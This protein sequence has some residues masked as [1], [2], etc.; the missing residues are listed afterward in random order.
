MTTKNT[1][2]IHC[3]WFQYYL[4]VD[5]IS[6][7]SL[8]LTHLNQ[9][10]TFWPITNYS[11]SFFLNISSRN[12]VVSWLILRT[13]LKRSMHFN[14][15]SKSKKLLE[16]S[17][18]CSYLDKLIFWNQFEMPIVFRVEKKPAKIL[19]TL[20]VWLAMESTQSSSLNVIS[21]LNL[22]TLYFFATRCEFSCWM[23]KLLHLISQ[24]RPLI[25]P[26]LFQYNERIFHHWL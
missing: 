21:L 6:D 8:C 3:K 12:F 4:I 16:I 14:S 18:V 24:I 1:T 25:S 10:K 26:R 7:W 15:I 11:P 17:V 23:G 9:S 20:N 13:N 5:F 2:Y 19:M 22:I